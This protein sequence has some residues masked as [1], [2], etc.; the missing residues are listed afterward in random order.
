MFKGDLGLDV[1]AGTRPLMSVLVIKQRYRFALV[2]D[3]M[4]CYI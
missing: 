3:R 2:A 1:Y 4:L